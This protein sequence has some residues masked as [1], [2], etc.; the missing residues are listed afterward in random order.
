[1]CKTVPPCFG[2]DPQTPDACQ[3]CDFKDLCEYIHANFVARDRL[4][5]ICEKL[6]RILTGVTA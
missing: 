2:L 6:E 4:Q 3:K 5:P 1:M